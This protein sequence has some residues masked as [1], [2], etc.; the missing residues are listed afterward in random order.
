MSE[1]N[2]R[3]RPI[4]GFEGAYEVSNQG[5]VRS[6]ARWV[7]CRNGKRLCDGALVR[8]RQYRSN[9][10]WTAQLSKGGVSKDFFVHRLVATAFIP[11]T[12]EIV[13]H[14]DGNGLNNVEENLAWGSYK[15]N[16]ADKLRHGRRLMGEA[17][18]MS[19][20]T[21]ASV[22]T[23]RDMHSNGFTQLRIAKELGIKRGTVGTVVRRECWGHVA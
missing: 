17:H 10:Y 8:L 9:K 7:V 21:E 13:R 2:E 5:R 11:K 18:G 4:I 20:I 22:R 6:V 3:W 15:D 1:E 23:I 19:K 14:L 16:E 12:G